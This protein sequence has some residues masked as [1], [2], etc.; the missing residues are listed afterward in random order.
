MLIFIFS[1]IFEYSSFRKNLTIRF[2][3]SCARAYISLCNY[4]YMPVHFAYKRTCNFPYKAVCILYIR[5][6]HGVWRIAW[7]TSWRICA[8]ASCV[9]VRIGVCAFVCICECALANKKRQRGKCQ[10]TTLPFCS[11]ISIRTSHKPYGKKSRYVASFRL[12]K[13][14]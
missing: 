3:G 13:A 5:R 11:D 7:R 4:V 9:L 10:K 14:G 12:H 8:C 2:F 1:R 6:G